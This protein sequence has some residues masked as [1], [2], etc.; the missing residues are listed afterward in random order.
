MFV[1]FTF[2]YSLYRIYGNNS[3]FPFS[4]VRNVFGKRVRAQTNEYCGGPWRKLSFQSQWDSGRCV[5]L[6]HS[7]KQKNWF[8]LNNLNPTI[9]VH[10]RSSS[11]QLYL[12]IFSVEFVLIKTNTNII[13]KKKLL[14]NYNCRIV[15]ISYYCKHKF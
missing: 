12:N 8:N 1:F 6:R 15:L 4:I 7:S 13:F 10:I 11:L 2:F 14:H 5:I 3:N 9:C